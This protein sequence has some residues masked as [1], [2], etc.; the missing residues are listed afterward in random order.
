[1]SIVFSITGKSITIYLRFVAACH[2][3]NKKL[4]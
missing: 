2:Y 3:V 1:M 4:F